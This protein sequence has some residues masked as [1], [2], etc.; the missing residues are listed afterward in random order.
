MLT[1]PWYFIALKK[2]N[3]NEDFEF[4]VVPGNSTESWLHER[5]TT[6]DSVLGR[7]PLYDT[8]TP[9]EVDLI[10]NW[11]DNGAPD[12]FG[13]SHTIPN[14][15][16]STFG[17]IAYLNDT[18]GMRLDTPRLSI[19]NPLVFPQN[20]VVDVWIGLIDQDPEGAFMYAPNLTYNKYKI[21]NNLYGFANAPEMPLLVESATSP[22]Q[23]P[24][25]FDPGGDPMNF[26][27]HFK[28]NTSN[29]SVGQ[30]QYFRIYV[31]DEDHTVPTEI[32]SDGSQVYLLTFFSF[33]I[34]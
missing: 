33:V 30:T 12:I 29:Y 23:G 11:I 22:F 27:Q 4:R 1:I 7:M 6:D 26:Y 28:V 2:N 9:R 16:P 8:L 25:L 3:A 31:Q 24:N 14:L 5:I 18:T 19:I 34:Q 10:T 13:N 17:V 20:S 32:P 15:S 21:S